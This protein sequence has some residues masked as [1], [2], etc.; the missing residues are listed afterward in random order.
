MKKT[1]IFL[2]FIFL[3]SVGLIGQDRIQRVE[4]PNWW[5][6]MNNTELQLLIYGD[7]IASWAPEIDYVG[8]TIASTVRTTNT[9]YIFIYL[10]IAAN[11]K[12]GT[13]D[14]VFKKD[15]K[16]VE[17]YAFSLWNREA[18]SAMREGFNTSDVMYLITPDRFVNGD[19]GNDNI[20]GMLEKANRSFEGGRH[21]GDIEGISKVW[22][23]SAT[24]DSRPF[25]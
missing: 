11:T 24:W 23:T 12:P 25:G 4:P 17:K 9:N 8:V 14:I 6:G 1:T 13:F 7:D 20:E 21:G 3:T 18:G 2:L 10:N 5:V 19:P 15:G 16:I 22:I